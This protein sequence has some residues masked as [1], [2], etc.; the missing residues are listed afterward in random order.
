MYSPT[1]T[2]RDVQYLMVY[3]ANTE[4][5]T[6]QENSHLWSTNGAGIKISPQFGF[7]AIDAE[8]MVSRARH[9]TNVPNQTSQ[10]FSLSDHAGYT[11]MQQLL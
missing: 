3:T 11:I 5:L 9:W 10:T 4:S 7:G 8:S 2:W 6:T 1:L